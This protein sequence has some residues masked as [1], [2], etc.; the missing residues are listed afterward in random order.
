VRLRAAL[1]SA[2]LDRH[3]LQADPPLPMT[4]IEHHSR[5]GRPAIGVLENPLE[6]GA[7]RPLDYDETPRLF[8]AATIGA[9]VE[10][11]QKEG[12]ASYT[13]PTIAVAVMGSK[14]G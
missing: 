7:V 13:P 1:V 9:Q 6:H 2:A 12:A 4:T 14:G 11:L 5:V 8:H 3:L 10:D